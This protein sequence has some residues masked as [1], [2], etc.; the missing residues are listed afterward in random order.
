MPFIRYT[1]DKRGYETTFV[2]HAYR[3]GHGSGRARILYLFRSPSNLKVG[4]RGLEP[5][6]TE[7]LEHTHP[8]LSFD[9]VSLLH[10]PAL[11][12]VEPREY[13]PRPRHRP[14]PQASRPAPV[15]TP[16]IVEDE[17]VLGRT[18]GAREAARLRARHNEVV[19][20][21]A[22]RSRTPEERDRLTE[23]AV[24]LNPD[25]WPDSAAIQAGVA[26]AEAE[27]TAI[28]GELPQ[29]RRGR[30]GGRL[31]GDGRPAGTGIISEEGQSHA[32]S[33]DAF[34]AGVDRQDLDSG[35]IGDSGRVGPDA[36]S[37]ADG[38]TAFDSD[39]GG[40]VQSSD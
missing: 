28:V 2:M 16:P 4:R 30:R 39:P 8:D 7:A 24:R 1:R 38:P 5:E 19:Q 13:G 11:P 33:H 31:R 18:V 35:G 17:S 32:P 37:E 3:A 26:S 29:R 9:W 34:Q 40:G 25:D 21:V 6:V 12:R 36:E 14:P 23:R 27:W 20:R 10:E 22:R 15:P